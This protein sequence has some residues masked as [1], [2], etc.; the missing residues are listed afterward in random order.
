LLEQQP[1]QLLM[2]QKARM[3][4]TDVMALWEQVP[5]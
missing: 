2:E 5:G 4:L 1:L 3:L